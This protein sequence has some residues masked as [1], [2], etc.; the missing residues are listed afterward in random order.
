MQVTEATNLILEELARR[1]YRVDKDN[2]TIEGFPIWFEVVPYAGNRLRGKVTGG[3]SEWDHI[4]NKNSEKEEAY[5]FYQ[6]MVR[7]IKLEV[8]EHLKVGVRGV[9]ELQELME[10]LGLY[11]GNPLR[12]LELFEGKGFNP[13]TGLLVPHFSLEMGK[14]V[15]AKCGKKIDW[16]FKL[17]QPAHYLRK[18]K[19]V[20]K[21]YCKKCMPEVKKQVEADL[22]SLRS[23]NAQGKERVPVQQP[24]T[25][26]CNDGP[27]PNV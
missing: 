18:M 5:P 26:G 20:N 12:L 11:S 8:D 9:R 16:Y 17:D 22:K 3:R 4:Q 14:K 6:V 27:L 7:H 21:V 15:C 1:G 19:V 10:G 23:E 25:E 24:S 13:G 2:T